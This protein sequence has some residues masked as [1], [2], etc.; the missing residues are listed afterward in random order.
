[1]SGI[2]G[3]LPW[4]G[5]LLYEN[6]YP[7]SI[8]NIILKKQFHIGGSYNIL[9]TVNEYDYAVYQRQN[10]SEYIKDIGRHWL[11]K[12]KWRKKGIKAFFNEWERIPE[13]EIKCHNTSGK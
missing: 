7:I 10:E 9:R 8:Q 1:M 5:V 6:V 3:I 12:T 13:N 4:Y 2:A 11:I